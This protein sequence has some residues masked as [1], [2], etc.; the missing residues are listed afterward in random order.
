MEVVKFPNSPTEWKLTPKNMRE[1]IADLMKTIKV[2][3]SYDIPYLAGY[4]VD[5]LTFYVDSDVEPMP[6]EDRAIDIVPFFM[7]HEFVEK[8]IL[9]LLKKQGVII[10]GAYMIAHQVAYAAETM[11]IE[12]EK[13]DR[14]AYDAFWMGLL[15]KAGDKKDPKCPPDLDIEPYKDEKDYE[16]IK[17][18]VK[19]EKEEAAESAAA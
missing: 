12:M 15:K 6:Y 9:L 14:K 18:I 2:V 11:A 4:S 19:G 10:E 5:G 8:S 7:L 17:K 16:V 13:I 3:R 1:T